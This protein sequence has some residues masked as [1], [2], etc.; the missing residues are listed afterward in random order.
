MKS[1]QQRNCPF[2]RIGKLLDK[3]RAETEVSFVS[4]SAFTLVE[5]LIVTAIVA[6]LIGLLAAGLS[7]AK[8]AAQRIACLNNLK[9]WGCAT[10]LYAH[11]NDDQ[12]PREAAFDGINPCEAT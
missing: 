9:Q 2:P 12:L 10:H 4:R 6:I 5:L 3:Q 1:H 11:D 8:M 7:R